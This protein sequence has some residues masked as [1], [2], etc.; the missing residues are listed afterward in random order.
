MYLRWTRSDDEWRGTTATG[1]SYVV[2]SAKRA[3]KKI[4]Y[5]DRPNYGT[6]VCSSI[7]H[8]REYAEELARLAGFP[9]Q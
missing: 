1:K 8:A 4:A 2:R 3:G 5:L 9:N 7:R 6:E